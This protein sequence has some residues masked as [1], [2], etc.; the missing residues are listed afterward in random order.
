MLKKTMLAAAIAACALSTSYA[1]EPAKVT[2]L[3][4]IQVLNITGALSKFG[5]Y[6]DPK[7]GTVV[8]VDF[9]F[10][11]RPLM[12]IATNLSLGEQAQKNYNAAAQKLFKRYAVMTDV[13]ELDKDEKPTGKM[14]QELRVPPDKLEE[15]ADQVRE[16][17]EAPADVQLSKLKQAELCI[18]AKPVDPCK[19]WN[20][21]SPVLISAI[22]PIIERAATP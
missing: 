2:D 19:V 13:P 8:R 17:Q 12:I 14:K 4:V 22:V 21:I 11:G 18:D 9:K 3:T 1:A 6:Q 15:Y 7:T 16:Q 5:D 20:N 10:D